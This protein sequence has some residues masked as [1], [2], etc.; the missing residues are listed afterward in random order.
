MNTE[1]GPIALGFACFEHAPTISAALINNMC[2]R[3][4]I[5]AK[6]PHFLPS[7]NRERA[8][9]Y[10][11]SS[12]LTELDVLPECKNQ[13][14]CAEQQHQPIAKSRQTIVPGMIKV[15]RPE[16]PLEVHRCFHWFG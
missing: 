4:F 10:L 5:R 8:D 7:V 9:R 11:P 13:Y 15:R 6:P 3:V 12:S 1:F 2:L 14:C 16:L